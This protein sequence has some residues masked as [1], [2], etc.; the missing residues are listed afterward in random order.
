MLLCRVQST[1][2]A[3]DGGAQVAGV[4]AGPR[5]VP[6]V[7]DDVRQLPQAAGLLERGRDARQAPSRRLRR[8]ALV[9]PFVKCIRCRSCIHV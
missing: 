7:S 9:P 6:A 5:R 2:P 3:A 4:V 1:K 8:A